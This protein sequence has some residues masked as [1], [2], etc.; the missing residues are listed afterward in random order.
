[1]VAYFRQGFVRG[2]D[3]AVF[4]G[5]YHLMQTAFPGT[6]RHDAARVFVDYLNL[7]VPH[8]VVFIYYLQMLGR[9]CLPHQPLSTAS[10]ALP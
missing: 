1:L 10:V 7:A 5:L 6:I 9:E 4:F 8:Q 3:L 2:R